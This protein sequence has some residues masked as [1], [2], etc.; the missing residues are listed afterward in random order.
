MPFR[1]TGLT[2]KVG[3][4][5]LNAQ[6]LCALRL[7]LPLC[8]SESDS[9]QNRIIQLSRK[10]FERL[11]ESLQVLDGLPD[12]SNSVRDFLA[13]QFGD[14]EIDRVNPCF[15]GRSQGAQRGGVL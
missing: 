9:I 13:L 3:L 15:F 12:F 14:F 1:A 6:I 10:L 8:N 4:E 5:P 11:G 2:E 7:E